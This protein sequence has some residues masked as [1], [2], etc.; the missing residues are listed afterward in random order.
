MGISGGKYVDELGPVDLP[1]RINKKSRVL[2]KLSC[3]AFWNNFLISS[4]TSFALSKSE[5]IALMKS[6]A[7]EELENRSKRYE[8][9]VFV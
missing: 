3:L 5:L 6:S 9:F 2:R 4:A 8:I 7:K 1:L